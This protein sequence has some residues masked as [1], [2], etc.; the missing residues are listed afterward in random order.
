[1]WNRKAALPDVLE[2]VVE[3]VVQNQH[4]KLNDD[5]MIRLMPETPS[6]HVL[7]ALAEARDQGRIYCAGGRWGS[8]AKSL[9]ELKDQ[10]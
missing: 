3:L 5:L 1:M 8:R 7:D 6:Y 2:T 10:S 4:K 9:H